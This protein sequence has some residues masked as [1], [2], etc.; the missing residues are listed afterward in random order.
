MAESEDQFAL[1]RLSSAEDMS[2]K[3]L[4]TEAN[5]GF[6]KSW[7]DRMTAMSAFIA[8]VAAGISAFN[9]FQISNLDRREKV[10]EA[11]YKFAQLFVEKVLA[12]KKLE[13]HE[14]TVQA[15]LTIL[16][17]V[18]QASSSEKGI[19]RA[20][21]RQLLPI[22]LALLLGE[23]GGVSELDPDCKHIE[24]WV[25]LATV[26]N[27][28]KTRVTAVQ[29]LAQLGQRALLSG[30]LEILDKIGGKMNELLN[31]IPR[32]GTDEASQLRSAALTAQSQLGIFINT[33][34][35][36][37]ENAKSGSGAVDEK[38]VR[39][40]IRRAFPNSVATAQQT[41]QQV[42]AQLNKVESIG[43]TSGSD[44]E[45][46]AGQL[47]KTLATLDV[48]IDKAADAAVRSAGS[49]PC[50]ALKSGPADA[51]SESEGAT[52][53]AVAL[54]GQLEPLNASDAERQDTRSKLALLGNFAIKPLLRKVEASPQTDAAERLNFDIGL[55][56]AQMRQPIFLDSADAATV[57]SMLY[58]GGSNENNLSKTRALQTRR[59][60]AEFLMDL[61]DG[62]SIQN[63]FQKLREAFDFG[64]SHSDK[65]HAAFN[66]ALIVGTW[67]R[68]LVTS[69]QSPE[70]DKPMRDYC[71]DYAKDWRKQLESDRDTWKVTISTLDDLVA[72]AEAARKMVRVTFNST[73][74]PEQLADP[75][76]HE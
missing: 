7:N 76:P 39:E 3:E 16:D 6:L 17:I 34:T 68:N 15:M 41:R 27:Q 38:T 36:A 64:V 33:N 31:L 35:A 4:K 1:D 71:L 20:E 73:L 9:T 72:R 69:I 70:S 58:L 37:F 13:D 21:A 46:L 28:D 74:P 29:A 47:R 24:D 51:P 5:P 67:A 65:R 25:T 32:G 10:E 57:V 54:I 43:Q 42:N 26:D 45:P 12:T 63:A 49:T 40:S 55:T 14:K 60:T 62:P 56:L 48:V 61:W 75:N 50:D 59:N 52:K 19:S 23:P 22:H 30:K 18:A 2:G 53:N 8:L 66:A 44:A 11:S